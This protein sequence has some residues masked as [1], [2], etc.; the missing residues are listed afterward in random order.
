MGT[1]VRGVPLTSRPCWDRLGL[2]TLCLRAKLAGFYCFCCQVPSFSPVNIGI[3]VELIEGS[4]CSLNIQLPRASS[5]VFT[6]L[7]QLCH[8]PMDAMDE[9][10]RVT[11]SRRRIRVRQREEME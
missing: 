2:W 7:P 11:W 5:L 9:W 1:S 8:G 3:V 6:S 10:A 4:S